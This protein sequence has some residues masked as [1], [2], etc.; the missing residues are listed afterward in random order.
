MVVKE[1]LTLLLQKTLERLTFSNVQFSAHLEMQKILE[2]NIKDKRYIRKT[3]IF[4]VIG[5]ILSKNYSG[6]KFS[7]H[8]WGLEIK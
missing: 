6:L 1:R 4:I 8:M 5:G 3:L 2:C 7:K